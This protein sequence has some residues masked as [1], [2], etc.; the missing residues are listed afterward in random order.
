MAKVEAKK[1]LEQFD[2]E[3]KQLFI[4]GQWQYEGLLTACIGGY[5]PNR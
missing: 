3:L 2:A 1:T 4:T 5:C